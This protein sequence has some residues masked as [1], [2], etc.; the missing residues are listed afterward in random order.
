MFL[1]LDIDGVMVPAASWKAPEN[2]EDG[3]PMFSTRAVETL[4]RILSEDTQIVLT[5]SH[6]SRFNPEEWKKIFERRGIK[7][8]KLSCLNAADNSRKR[9]DEL[10]DWFDTPNVG[11]D[12]III[13]DDN[14]L[15]ALPP[16]LKEH[17]I[18]T[19]SLIGL[20]QDHLAQAGA[21]LG[22]K[23]QQA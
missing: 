14:S 3:F 1:F 9:K 18:V 21:I 22:T 23:L 6:K 12:F 16:G 20:T 13:D 8:N 15:R 2:L 7:I 10:I 5:T 4:K 17:L 11:K 19:S